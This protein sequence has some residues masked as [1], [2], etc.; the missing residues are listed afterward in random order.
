MTTVLLFF[1]EVFGNKVAADEC[2]DWLK[3]TGEFSVSVVETQVID[4]FS[5]PEDYSSRYCTGQEEDQSWDYSEPEEHYECVCGY[6]SNDYTDI[7]NHYESCQD[8]QKEKNQQIVKDI[9]DKMSRLSDDDICRMLM[10]G[11]DI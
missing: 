3:A 2:A 7:S 4:T 10:G 1:V 5:S 11:I 8:A 6:I 9:T